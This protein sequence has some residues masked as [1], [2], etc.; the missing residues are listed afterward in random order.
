[1]T[2]TI[3]IEAPPSRAR[4]GPREPFDPWRD[5]PTAP[6]PAAEVLDFGRYA[7]WRIADLV[8]H[9]PDYVRWLS[10]HST[11]VRFLETIAR[12]LPGDASVGRRSSYVG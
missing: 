2:A 12:C 5:G 6:R 8:R 10:R 9:D 4:S 1:R 3:A 11:G 7:G